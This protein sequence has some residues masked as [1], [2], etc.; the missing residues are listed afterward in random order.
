MQSPLLSGAPTYS[1]DVSV[2]RT[3]EFKRI[4]QIPVRKLDPRE[5]EELQ[6]LLTDGLKTP[7][8]TMRLELPQA[9]GL[10]EAYRNKG[11]MMQAPVGT[12]KSLITYTIPTLLDCA[13]PLLLVP[14]RMLQRTIKE[15]IPE[16]GRHWR[17]HDGIKVIS[18][19][20][21]QVAKNQ[22]LLWELM[23]TD[24]IIDEAQD[25]RNLHGATRVNRLDKYL[26]EFPDTRL[27]ELSGSFFKNSINDYAH[28]YFWALPHS[29]CLPMSATERG[30]WCQA[31]DVKVRRRIRPGA[32]LRFLSKKQRIAYEYHGEHAG[33]IQTKEDEEKALDIV[34]EGFQKRLASCAG[35]LI[36]T[37]DSAPDVS[38]SIDGIFPGSRRYP[39]APE[40]I[41]DAFEKLR[42]FGELPGDEWVSDSMSVWRTAKELAC[43]FYNRW[44]WKPE[45]DEDAREKWINARK[46]WKKF[47]RESIKKSRSTPPLDSELLVWNAVQSGKLPSDKWEAYEQAGGDDFA[48]DVKPVWL[49]DYLVDWLA[50]EAIRKPQIIWVDHPALGKKIADK[51][52]FT[53]YGAGDEGI[54][55][56][57]GSISIL[58]SMTA[59]GKGSNLQHAFGD[60]FIA[61]T[62]AG[63]DKLEQVIG[64]T[65]RKG[66]KRD[67][68]TCTFLF[69]CLELWESFNNAKAE[70]R[71]QKS[72]AGTHKLLHADYA[73]FPTA[74]DVLEWTRAGNDSM[75]GVSKGKKSILEG[76]RKGL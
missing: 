37:D 3:P 76:L 46:E 18:T 48:P 26:D 27:Y 64:R 51:Y 10:T 56:E 13:R 38:I 63:G 44:L 34:R 28:L 47:V 42:L 55:H 2:K 57:D 22:E 62:C 35:V 68:V 9:W 71:F 53:Y 67:L 66:Q 36:I 19:E 49:S 11:L 54:E 39:K 7:R 69:N 16:Y 29:Y 21:L 59:Q 32:L 52:G 24:I 73:E 12:G 65:H 74:E 15:R 50:E 23:P 31:L 45:V 75:W 17:I 61:S 43:G 25:F 1:M 72:L 58:A 30:E 8:G 40:K 60:N 70:A 4:E 33:R 14:A 5:G 20:S 41:Q 6:E